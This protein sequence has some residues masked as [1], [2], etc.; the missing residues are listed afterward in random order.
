MIVGMV[1]HKKTQQVFSVVE[2]PP[3]IEEKTILENWGGYQGISKEAAVEKFMLDTCGLIL[4]E[5][6]VK[7]WEPVE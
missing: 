2:C 3:G 6:L 1:K 5:S 7:V 4:W